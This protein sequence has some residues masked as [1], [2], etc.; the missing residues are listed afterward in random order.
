M[1]GDR[2]EKSQ[3]LYCAYCLTED[4]KWIIVACSN[5]KGDLLETNL[6]NI[7]VPN[8]SKR[9]RT[10]VKKLGLHKILDFI[11][12]V[13]TESVQPWRLIIG[14]VGR[15]GH[16]ELKEWASLLSKKS[17]LRY[18]RILKE[19]CRQCSMMTSYEIPCILS[20]CM[21]SLE[22]DTALRVFPDQFTPDDR[23]NSSSNT[24]HLST[25]EEASCTHILVFPTSTTTQS[26]QGQ[27]QNDPLG[28]NLGD[29]DLLQAL[30][31]EAATDDLNVDDIFQWTEG[32]GLSLAE[33]ESP[34][35]SGLIQPDSPRQSGFD[36]NGSIKVF[37]IFNSFIMI[38]CYVTLFSLSICLICLL[39]IDFEWYSG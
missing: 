17:L 28:Q 22:A 2:P 7:G 27:Y 14:R 12:A 20:A 6:I 5:D 8:R 24:C 10:S 31:G 21:I 29:D 3:A 34:R 37:P 25:P 1:F 19:K 16:G 15:V 18:N 36:V 38:H 13:M 11:F 39:Q 26:S 30:G 32:A 23:F 4:Q 9:K 33:S 35:N